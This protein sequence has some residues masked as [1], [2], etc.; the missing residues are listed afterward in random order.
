MKPSKL[1][2]HLQSKHPDLAKKSVEYFQRI[3]ESMQK[4]ISSLAFKKKIHVSGLRD[5]KL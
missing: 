1:G 3:R 2:R 4:Q 5:S